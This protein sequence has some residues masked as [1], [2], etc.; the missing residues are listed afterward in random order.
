MYVLQK[1]KF[2]MS[3]VQIIYFWIGDFIIYLFL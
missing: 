3:L 1:I 2:Q